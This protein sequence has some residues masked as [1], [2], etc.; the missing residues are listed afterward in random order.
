MARRTEVPEQWTGLEEWAGTPEFRDMLHREFPE[1]A[2]AWADPVSRRT[3]LTLA[4]ATVAL[5]G[6]GCSPRPASREKIYPYVRQP[7]QLTLGLPLFFATGFTLGG[8]T[9][10]VLAKS[11]EGRPIKLEG[12]PSHPGSLGSIDSIAQASIL[13]LYDPDR[14]RQITRLNVPSGWDTAVSTLRIALDRLRADGKAIRI[15]T[16]TVG[17]PSLGQAL[18]DLQA[19]FPTTKWIQYEPAGRDNVREGGKLAYGAY[20]NTIYDFTKALRVVSLDAD[21]LVTGPSSVRYARDFNQLRSSHI[22]EG[23]RVPTADEMNRLYVVESMLTA[24][25]AVADHRVP[26]RSADV[27]AFTRALARELG[28]NAGDVKAPG[29]SAKMVS[30]IAKDLQA[31][32][33]RSIVIAGDHHSSAVHAL[34]H[35]INGALGNIGT[36][37]INTEPVEVKATNQAEEFKALVAEMNA[38]TVGAL[39]I[40]GVNPVFTSPADVEFKAA[41]GRVGLKVHLGTHVDETAVLC[42]WH[43]N[44]AHYLETWGDGRAFDGTASISQPLI[45]PLFNGHSALELIAYLL[46]DRPE[47]SQQLHPRE[48][49]KAYWRKNWPTNGGSTTNFDSAW[50]AALRDG[51]IP[52]TARARVDKQPAANVPAYTPPASGLE[53]NFRADPTIFDGRFSNNGWLQ[54]VPKPITKLTW[55]NAV[56]LSPKTAK[57]NGLATKIVST[58]GGEHGRAVVPVVELTVG[59]RTLKA[60]VWI[61]PG[62]ADDSITL[63]FGYGREKGG[64]VG[65]GTGFNTYNLRGSDAPWNAV[66]ATLKV[67]GEEYILACTQSHFNMEGRRPAR[68]ADRADYE[69]NYT[70]NKKNPAIGKFAKVPAVA[71]KEW[72]AID[73]LVPGN[74]AAAHRHEE[75]HHGEAGAEKKE[76][77]DHDSRTVPLS[78]YPDT[79]KD[80]RR[81]AMAIDLTK[82][83]GC[84]ACITACIAEN[85]I[86]VVGKKE[87]IRGREMH[88][89][90]VD[91]Y[92]EGAPDDA[93]NLT[94]HFQP[95]PCQ[96]CEKA[97]CEVV[98]PVAA[99]THSFD[100][101]NDMV[102]NRCVGTR[103]CSNNCPY[104]VRRF[105]FLTFSDWKT[106]TYKLMRNPEVTTR[107]RGVMEKCTYCVQRI[108]AAEIEVERVGRPV[109]DGEV[110]TACQ[111]ACPAEAISFGDLN[112]VK[113]K[114]NVWKKQPTNYGLLAE[115][116]T[117]PRTTYLAAVRNPNPELARA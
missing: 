44:E 6:I 55:D 91:R 8:I 28:V 54:E 64:K 22:K 49:V 100:G 114:V 74:E 106:D 7:E 92:Y 97:P 70:E 46:P 101:L 33:G 35:A 112:D 53:V 69:Q 34:V 30:A 68:Q 65:Y 25:G 15:L 59:G 77:H 9:T 52:G 108:R 31:F 56:I 62:H 67:T 115:L 104:K 85:N 23:D 99:T 37:V 71:A 96:Q 89:I 102:Y 4:G 42:D 61:Q 14:S 57:A 11:R 5:A 17:S 75:H 78:M 47:Q 113:S 21:F 19:A 98:C 83:I 76:E 48:V 29:D 116:N 43:I 111:Q 38:G 109:R 81:W 88:W 27:D 66:G 39:F 80:H 16:D 60:A 51:V 45:A 90:R 1:D 10:G 58:G 79:N 117:M 110:L 40:L 63:H 103:Y 41:L 18:A 84:S 26:M 93:S 13:N 86:P 24:T 87:V 36:T 95:I 72:Q 73:E 20:V 32:K 107:E 82:C 12:N 2:T 50:Q 3:F 105:N 94:T